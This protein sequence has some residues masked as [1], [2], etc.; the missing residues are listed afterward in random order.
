[1]RHC[2]P[3]LLPPDHFLPVRTQFTSVVALDWS[4]HHGCFCCVLF[5]DSS[6]MVVYDFF[7]S[8]SSLSSKCNYL[9]AQRMFFCCFFFS[10]RVPLKQS[11]SDCLFSPPLPLLS[12]LFCSVSGNA[13]FNL[14]AIIG[15][16]FWKWPEVQCTTKHHLL[17]DFREC[18]KIFTSFH[19]KHFLTYVDRW[20]VVR[21]RMRMLLETCTFL[22]ASKM[23][24]PTQIV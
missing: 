19:N 11:L 5:I 9:Y 6:S 1:M 8:V 14:K 18:D 20:R 15:H 22:L 13:T 4:G 23:A 10:L 17:F 24:K 7:P 16:E 21:I 3:L 12:Y 2:C